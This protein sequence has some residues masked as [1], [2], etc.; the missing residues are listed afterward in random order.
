M[1]AFVKNNCR[2]SKRKYISSFPNP[3]NWLESLDSD[4][5]CGLEWGRCISHKIKLM[6][7]SE[8]LVLFKKNFNIFEN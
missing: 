6:S 8:E 1:E 2:D 5:D 7:E 3:P 4:E